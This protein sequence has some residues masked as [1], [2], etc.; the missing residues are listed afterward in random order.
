M[1][2]SAEEVKEQI[3]IDS[4]NRNPQATHV[5]VKSTSGSNTIISLSCRPKSDQ[6]LTEEAIN[7]LMKSELEKLTFY[8]RS[9]A[10]FEILPNNE[11]IDRKL[12][13]KIQVFADN[14]LNDQNSHRDIR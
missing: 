5:V 2:I 13:L 9:K 12:N 8:A 10:E 4:L 14:I 7:A 3:S 1:D 6:S 11:D